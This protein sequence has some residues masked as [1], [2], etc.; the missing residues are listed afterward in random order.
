MS[1]YA[2]ILCGGS[3]TRMGGSEN[4]TL[5]RIGGE[6]GIVRCFRAFQ[7]LVDGIVLV[8][9]SG[10]ETVFDGTLRQRG[11]IPLAI[12]PGGGDRQ[13]SA[14]CGLKALPPDADIALIHD[15]ARPFVTRD[16]IRRVIDSVKEH[17]SGVA[18]VPAR[19]TL[20][21]ASPDGTV[22]ETLNRA[23][24]WQMQTTQGFFV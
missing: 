20:K 17:G 22:L 14:L 13:A 2:I 11:L 21:R 16:V 19:D 15:G 7:G 3:G 1:A 9:R 4:K 24:L 10:E 12:V 6:P 18:A 5:L 8:T 23:E